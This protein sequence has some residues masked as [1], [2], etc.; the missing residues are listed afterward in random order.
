[1]TGNDVL[2]LKAINKSF[3]GVL[4]LDNVDFSL[5]KGEVHCLLG[6]NGAGKSTLLKILSGVYAQDSGSIHFDGNEI[7]NLNIQKARDLGV[8]Q[9]YQEL[10]LVPE[11]TVLE[12]IFL[13]NEETGIAGKMH[14]KKMAARTVNVLVEL[15]MELSP[16]AKI[17]DLSTAQQQ[18]VEIAKALVRENDILLFDEPTDT[19]SKQNTE[20]LFRIIHKLKDKGVSMIYISHRLEEFKHIAD[21]VT[22]MRDGKH[23]G[24]YDINKIS[25]G[26]LVNHM[27]GRQLQKSHDIIFKPG[28]TLLTVQGLTRY[29]RVVDVSFTVHEG[30]IVG[31][32]GLIGSGRTELMR[33]I[34]GADQADSGSLTY[35]GKDINIKSPADAVRHGIGLLPE[36]RK[37][38][39]LVLNMPVR[40]NI[41]LASLVKFVRFMS[42]HKKKEKQSAEEK[43]REIQINPPDPERQAGFLSGGNQQKVVLAKWLNTD[44]ELFIFDEPTR[45]IDVGARAEIYSLMEALIKQGKSII[46]VSS[47]L[48]EILRMS[49]RILVMADGKISG[50]LKREESTQE[51]I[52]SLMLGD[53]FNAA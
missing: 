2:E 29:P 32:A 18:M 9:I 51:K 23:V 35:K 1:M 36:D 24:T 53:K 43:I 50:E 14:W 49:R 31:F 28:P 19:L 47:D 25:L 20:E 6:E 21:R 40:A 44:C 11:L 12:N 3:P 4:A 17:K 48:P 41:S 34:F 8:G 39:G 45:G 30:E 22:V 16:N 37:G 42:L 15:G 26:E 52:M 5:R 33:L 38:Q 10:M 27:V 7:K 46:L 13:G